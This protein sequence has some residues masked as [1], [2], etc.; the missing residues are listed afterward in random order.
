MPPQEQPS[1][2][3]L[4]VD[5]DYAI[6]AMLMEALEDAGYRA[7][8]AEHGAQALAQLHES[9][10][11]PK[12]ILLDLMMPVMSG[13]EF[14]AAQQADARLAAIPVVVLSARPNIPNESQAMRVDGFI[15]KPMDLMKLLDIVERYCA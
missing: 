1:Y 3:V 8:S 4:V 11:L 10:Q 15:P 9:D 13:W 7:M 14:R 2:D 6:R 5:D 12:L